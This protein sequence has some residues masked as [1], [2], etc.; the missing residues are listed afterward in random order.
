MESYEAIRDNSD[1]VPSDVRKMWIEADQSERMLRQTYDRLAEDSDLTAEARQRKATEVYEQSR[2][3]IESR[4]QATRQALLKQVEYA[5]KAAIPRPS[6][7][8]LSSNDPTKMLIEQNEAGRLVRTIERRRAQGGPFRHDTGDFLKQEYKRGLE[9]GGLEGGSVC[10]GVLRAAQELGISHEEV[11]GSLRDERHRES[12]DRARRLEMAADTINTKP[13]K[14]PKSFEK[15]VRRGSF[16]QRPNP[17]M[18]VSGTSTQPL[19]QSAR[20]SRRK[21]SF[22]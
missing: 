2:E 21:K 9:A 16:Q 8:P 11:I 13:P 14:P 15:A 18:I 12:L 1:L 3:R 4:K 5:E 10:R 19:Q 20:K 17:T 6:G 7:E 22:K